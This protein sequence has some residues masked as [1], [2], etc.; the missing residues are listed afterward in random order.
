MV[1]S[2]KQ[3]AF[4]E[5]YLITR[6]ASESAR[7]AGYSKKTARQQGSNLLTKV[8]IQEAI[9][10]RTKALTMSADEA[11]M[12]LTNQARAN[13]NDFVK[14]DAYGDP[15][16]DL[17]IIERDASKGAQIRSVTVT[18]KRTTKQVE[19]PVQDEQG[20]WNN[21]KVPQDEEVLTVKFD[22][23]DAQSALKELIK[24]QR[25]DEGKAT[26]QIDHKH[27]FDYSELSDDE[28]RR[29]AGKSAG[30]RTG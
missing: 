27:T 14:L 10:E 3:R 9:A 28:L 11:L 24:L 4:V 17:S 16:V 7:L 23:Y 12:R 6:N 2:D 26:E 20:N 5:H 30:T 19:I 8:Y 25:L 1:L 29:I 13:I 21:E 18:K 15:M 22:L